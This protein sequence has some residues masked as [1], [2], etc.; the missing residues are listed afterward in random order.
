MR[1]IGITGFPLKIFRGVLDRLEN[2]PYR[3][4]KI[5]TVL[6]YCHYSLNNTTLAN[7]IPYLKS[8]GMGIINA[9]ALSMGLLTHHGPPE[10]HPASQDIKGNLVKSLKF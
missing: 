4:F 3:D 9:S 1:H 7:E 6:S 2:S 5:D 8:H 10:W